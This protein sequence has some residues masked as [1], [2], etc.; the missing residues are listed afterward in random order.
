MLRIGLAIVALILV[1]LGTVA[2]LWG[3]S[4]GSRRGDIGIAGIGRVPHGLVETRQPVEAYAVIHRE[5]V[6]YPDPYGPNPFGFIPTQWTERPQLLPLTWDVRIV[7]A[8]EAESSA[9]ET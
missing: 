4:F 7:F 9:G 6:W 3:D 8:A 1:C 2:Q 5:V